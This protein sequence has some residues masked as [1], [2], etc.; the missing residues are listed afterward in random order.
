MTM[1]GAAIPQ[2]SS[3]TKQVNPVFGIEKAL[4][5]RFRRFFC[6]SWVEVTP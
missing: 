5:G 6:F 2:A 4:R 3:P 1:P